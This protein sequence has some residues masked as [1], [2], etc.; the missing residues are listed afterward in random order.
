MTNY[1]YR[2]NDDVVVNSKR[3]LS[4]DYFQYVIRD[5]RV[6]TIIEKVAK[7]KRFSEIVSNTKPYG[8][9]KYLF[10]EPDRYPN[11]KLQSEPFEN[12]VKIFGVK[13]VKGGAKR[14]IGH[15]SPSIV[16]NNLNSINKYKLFFTTSYS[17]DAT[18][19]PEIIIG[20]PNEVCTE[21]FLLI[22]P[23]VSELLQRNCLSYMKTNFFKILLYFGKGT[24]QVTKSVFGLIP[25][26]DFSESW[27]DEKL[28]KKYGLTKEEI[29][30]IERMIRPME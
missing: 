19:P 1:T 28:Y 21:T 16:T 14:I 6:L 25:L 23:F 17:T 27:T 18:E 26:Q 2:S 4:N 9:R 22:G 10:N 24:M 7:G 5:S 11:S 12:S 20:K 29:D 30:F 8:I 3:F 15:I 13:G